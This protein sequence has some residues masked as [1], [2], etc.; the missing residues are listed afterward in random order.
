[1]RENPLNQLRLLDAGNHFQAPAA[2]HAPL[3]LDAARA[4]FDRALNLEIDAEREQPPLDG[5]S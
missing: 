3:D 4:S 1:V 5:Y 2:A